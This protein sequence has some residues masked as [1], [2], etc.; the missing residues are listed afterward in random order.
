[1]NPDVSLIAAFLVGLLG[2]THCLGM[3][4]G[5]VS[6][7]TFGLRDDLRRSPVK[8]LPYLLTYNL[9]RIASYAIAGALVGALGAGLFGLTPSPVARTLARLITG[10]FMIAL[11]LYLA[12]WWPGLQRLE[13]WGSVLWSRI[14]PY[15]R[16]LLPVDRPLK[17]LG[18]GLVWGWLPCGMVYA[19]LATALG[20]GGP[21]Q[22]AAFMMAF[23][24][25]TLPMLLAI[26]SVAGWFRNVVQRPL[27][28]IGAAVL[29]IAF[30]VYTLASGFG[31]RNAVHHHVAAIGSATPDI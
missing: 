17:A 4:G 16:R 15:G 11:G 25:G 18:F 14:E 23:G 7:L 24:L 19:A 31:G 13:Q 10:A 30:G 22:G 28:R 12:G 5:I 3:C 8:L 29:I 1:M 9:G 2:S 27:V 6:A 21:L 26:G 20:A